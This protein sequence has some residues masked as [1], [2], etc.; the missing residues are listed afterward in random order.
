MPHEPGVE[1]VIR[2]HGELASR[3]EGLVGPVARGAVATKWGRQ[4][5]QDYVRRAIGGLTHGHW[6]PP[7]DEY[8]RVVMDACRA[9]VARV[10]RTG[11]PDWSTVSFG[12]GHGVAGVNVE[13]ST[14]ADGQPFPATV[15]VCVWEL[16]I[17]EDAEDEADRQ[18]DP[19]WVERVTARL[20]GIA[21]PVARARGSSHRHRAST[22]DAIFQ[23]A[24][25][26]LLLERPAPRSAD[27][28]V[29]LAL[30]CGRLA[31][32]SVLTYEVIE[33]H[34]APL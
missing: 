4:E 24:R 16:D 10:S 21:G 25:Q 9:V 23:Y 26:E 2:R 30:T 34:T 3:S 20:H 6:P 15:T 29:D 14:P 19:Q 13:V 31:E 28:L 32:A 11:S 1:S 8:G 33:G 5:D 27:E 18:P 12:P 22:G 17:M 7:A